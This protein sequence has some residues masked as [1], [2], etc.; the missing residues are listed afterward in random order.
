M[1]YITDVV[2]GKAE[3]HEIDDYIDDWHILDSGAELEVS[4]AAW[5]GM[6]EEEYQLFLE[7]ESNLSII[8]E[9]YKQ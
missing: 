9:K 2:S 8:I 1:S 5:L 3:I 7:D 4:L 6:T